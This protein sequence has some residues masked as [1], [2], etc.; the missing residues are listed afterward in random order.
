MYRVVDIGSGVHGLLAML[1]P[2]LDYVAFCDIREKQRRDVAKI[3][4]YLKAQMKGVKDVTPFQEYADYREMILKAK[5]DIVIVRTPDPLHAPM[6]IFALDHGANVFVEKPMCISLEEC[7]QMIA[8]VKRTGLKLAVNQCARTI[9]GCQTVFDLRDRGVLGTPY[10]IR[11]EY[12]HG[13]LRQQIETQEKWRNQEQTTLSGSSHSI[14]LILG[15]MRVP[16]ESVFAGGSKHMFDGRARMN[17][18]DNVLIRF[19]GGRTGY[20]VTSLG[21]WR[22]GLGMAFELYGTKQDVIQT[23]TFDENS[24]QAGLRFYDESGG[25]TKTASEFST[26]QVEIEFGHGQ[27]YY[28]QAEN[29]LYA[30]EHDVKQRTMAD[31]IDGTRTVAVALAADESIK[32]GAA[33]NV[34]Q[35]EPLIYRGKAPA[36]DLDDYQKDLLREFVPLLSS[37]SRKRIL[38]A[39]DGLDLTREG[40]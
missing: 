19:P 21:C 7:E 9:Q 4:R 5:P 25:R 28:R 16:P 2:K 26:T 13:A 35:W 31:V 34:R 8:A 12:L 38:A 27:G 22:R 1:N 17:D 14:D 40:R 37:E 20:S 18:M 33:V 24:A 29:L 6:S 30:I 32:T 36:W 23:V 15:L 3:A 11:S 39:P 10:Y